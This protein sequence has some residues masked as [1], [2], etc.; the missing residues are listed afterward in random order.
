LTNCS[1]ASPGA[2]SEALFAKFSEWLDEN[3]EHRKGVTAHMSSPSQST[4]GTDGFLAASVTPAHTPDAVLS[5]TPRISWHEPLMTYQA[6]A[7]FAP[8]YARCRQA[9]EQ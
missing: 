4:H 5:Q 7:V 2:T 1:S 9:L 3:P 6:L 8:R